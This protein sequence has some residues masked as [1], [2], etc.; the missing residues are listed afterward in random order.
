MSPVSFD[1]HDICS[2][3]TRSKDACTKETR[4]VEESHVRLTLEGERVCDFFCTP[5]ELA[6]LCIGQLYLRGIIHSAEEVFLEG[7]QTESTQTEQPKEIIAHLLPHA[8]KKGAA[9]IGNEGKG[10]APLPPIAVLRE[11]ASRMFSLAEIYPVCGGVHCAALLEER[12]IVAFKEDIGRHNAMDKVIGQA[13]QEKRDFSR[14]VYLTSGRVNAEIIHKAARAGLHIVVSRSIVST[15]ALKTAVEQ[16]IG[17]V[18]RIEWKE[19]I[20]YEETFR[21]K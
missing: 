13:L 21:K 19:P 4:T 15:I 16:G 12:N 18:G 17:L 3:D 11:A 7:T 10:S 9:G 5:R 6:E 1:T 14:L 8:E 20:V 2:K